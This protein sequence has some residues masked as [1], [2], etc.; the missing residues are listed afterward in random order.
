MEKDS[1]S[2]TFSSGTGWTTEVGSTAG[3][4]RGS[5][6]LGICSTGG[7]GRGWGETTSL[8]S[9]MVLSGCVSISE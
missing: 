1:F 9:L 8:V 7:P 4:I 2:E 6:M 5:E 3:M